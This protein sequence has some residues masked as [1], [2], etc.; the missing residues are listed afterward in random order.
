MISVHNLGEPI[1]AELVPHLFTPLHRGKHTEKGGRSIGLGLYILS[2]ARVL[3]SQG[4]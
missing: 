2:G 1:S 3:L 4:S